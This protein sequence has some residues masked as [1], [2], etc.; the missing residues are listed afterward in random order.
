MTDCRNA[1]PARVLLLKALLILPLVVYLSG[2][3]VFP[4]I[5][6]HL[7]QPVPKVGQIIRQ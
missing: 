5:K 7:L 1:S 4:Y 2:D 6:D 3:S